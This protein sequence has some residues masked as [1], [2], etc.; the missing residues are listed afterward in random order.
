[1]TQ[2]QKPK[3]FNLPK[4]VHQALECH[5][6]GQLS[7]AEKLYGDVLAIRPDYF[8]AL[9]MLGL[10]KLNR[11]EL[12][13]ALHMMSAALRARPRSPDVLLNYGL[14][15]NALGRNEEALATFDQVLSIKKRS[16][17]AHNNRGAILERLGRTEEALQSI[18]R[19]LEIKPGHVDSLYNRASVLQKLGCHEEALKTFDRVLTIKPDY[20][21]AHNN[22]GTVLEILG[23]R[24]EALASY[25][26]A[27]E[28]NPNFVEAL[29]NSANALL[30][31][32]R[33]FDAVACYER[34]LAIDPRHAEVLHNRGNALAELGRHRE[35]LES[36]GRAIAVNPN[37]INAQWNASLLQLR[38]GNF[39]AGWEQYEWRWKRGEGLKKKRNFSQPL[40]L[41]DAPIAGRT[42]LLHAE[43]GFGDTIQ[44]VRYAPILVQRGANVIVEVQPPL[45]SLLAPIGEGVQV[46]GSGEAMPSFDLHCPLLSL[47]LAFRTAFDTIPAAVPYLVAPKDRLDL[48]SGRLPGRGVLRVGIAWSGSAT[49]ADDR[50]R[51]IALKQLKPLFDVH[52]VQFVSIQKEIGDNDAQ[53]LTANARIADL[54][55]NL[56]DYSDTAA[57]VAQLDMVISVD[58]S[59]AHLAGAL[60]KQVWVLL[61]FCPDWRWLL[62][63]D[64]SPWYPTARL[65]RQPRI[66]DWES[67]IA[68]VEGELA[69]QVGAKA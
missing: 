62:D 20:D 24:D 14:V 30:K 6:R 40:W 64:D 3:V 39:A 47:P 43:Q 1:M 7:Q 56:S 46:I 5:R 11:G 58:T 44:F 54:H 59:V 16:V 57:V 15:L 29:N 9:H 19:A 38:L 17:E 2:L 13:G 12:A 28:L 52:D 66:K 67:V 27:L 48:W 22:R 65:F 34:A 42:I 8:E 36:V 50:N 26:R 63:R 23:R 33:H 53:F 41:G 68:K 21:K 32:G 60:G 51:S 25:D 4:A 61:P 69:R 35:A 49:H 31:L 18:D 10:I 37:Y 55:A 45:K